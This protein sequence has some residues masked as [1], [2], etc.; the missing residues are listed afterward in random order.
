MANTSAQ[1]PKSSGASPLGKLSRMLRSMSQRWPQTSLL[2]TTEGFGVRRID[3]SYLHIVYSGPWTDAD[4]R[5]CLALFATWLV[6]DPERLRPARIPLDGVSLTALRES[7]RSSGLQDSQPTRQTGSPP[8]DQTAPH[9][10][11]LV[12]GEFHSGATASVPTEY[13]S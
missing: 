1:E 4:M 8:A 10:Q 3:G 12:S 11:I 9:E 5:D 13:G 2:T 6:A 7:A